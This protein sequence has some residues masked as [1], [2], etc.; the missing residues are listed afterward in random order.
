[1]KLWFTKGL[2]NTAVA[3]SM[4]ANDPLSRDMALLASHVDPLHPLRDVWQKF[5]VEPADAKGA[6]YADWVYMTARREKIDLVIVQRQPRSL[7][8]HRERF[9]EAGIELLIPAMPEVL[10]ILDNKFSF[11]NDLNVPDLSAAGVFGHAAI[12]FAN[13]A[14]FDAGRERLLA[15]GEAP[16]GLCVKPVVGIF[17]SGFRRIDDDGNEFERLM[18]TD[19]EDLYRI[20]LGGFRLA[21]GRAEKPRPMI[22]MPYLPGPERSVDFVAHQGELIAAVARRKVGKHQVLE[23]SGPAIDIVRKLARRYRL[24][25]QC[26]LQTREIDGRQIVLEIN[27]R[28]SGG[29]AMSCL[30]G[31]NLP[32]LAVLAASGR[33]YP[34]PVYLTN[35]LHVAMVEKAQIINSDRL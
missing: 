11:Q 4:I 23:V 32:L 8:P 30:A 20:S 16:Y 12:P 27:A 9:A 7:W 33:V 13:L 6:D 21:L 10:D 5:L 22:L 17:G 18:S 26:N 25:G 35:R 29:M 2:S 3:M 1:M 15:S 34:K 31:V 24:N 14:E 19:P 28:M